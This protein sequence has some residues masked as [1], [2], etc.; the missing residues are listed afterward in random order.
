MKTAQDGLHQTALALFQSA[1]NSADPAL[2][3]TRAI[4]AHPLPPQPAAGRTVLLAVG[5]AAVPMMRAAR[6][7]FP[8]ADTALVITNTENKTEISGVQLL[9]GGHPL[10]DEASAAAGRA[11]LDLAKGL[12]SGDRLIALISG[13]GSALMV[14]PA[15]GLTLSD[16]ARVGADLLASG[17]DITQMNLIRQNLSAIKG[18]G[19]L[20]AA[21]PAEVHAYI[22]SDVIGDDLRAIASGPTVSPIGSRA[23]AKSVMQSANIWT[24]APD[25][26]RAHLNN[27]EMRTEKPA[28]ARNTLI[29][30]NRQSL[31]A[32]R[33]AASSDWQVEIIT[34]HLTGDVTDAAEFIVQAAI[35]AP[36]DRP[37]ALLFG[38]E[39]TVQIAGTGLGGRNQELALR[40]AQQAP[41]IAGN[42]LFLSGGTDGRDGPTE[43]AGGIVTPTT[44]ED[45]RTSGADPEAL[46]ANNDSNAALAAADAL[47]TT[48]GT[49]TNVADVQ[50]FL[51]LPG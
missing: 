41:R 23:E 27:A 38:G 35:N 10:P 15:A 44:W 40:V 8:E 16:K 22:L 30:S 12:Q 4:A 21:A 50:I 1:V 49:G 5:K 25:A 14:A 17:L 3:L 9:C 24:T 51:R 39:T 18:G 28:P 46:L 31:N 36:T 6:D 11:A 20:R 13:G 19:L 43:A 48:G 2:A 26:V 34:D 7:L 42:W 32:M 29:G 33:D 45:I 47:L 37:V